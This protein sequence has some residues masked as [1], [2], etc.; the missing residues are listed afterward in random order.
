MWF[1]K[2]IFKE[3]IFLNEV[4]TKHDLHFRLVFLLL[5]EKDYLDHYKK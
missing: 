5:N 2:I 3:H 4:K 1:F